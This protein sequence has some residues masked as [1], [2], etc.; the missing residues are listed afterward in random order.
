MNNKA[1][2]VAIAINVKLTANKLALN[3]LKRHNALL[4]LKVAVRIN[5][6]STATAHCISSRYSRFF[7]R[8]PAVSMRLSGASVRFSFACGE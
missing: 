7:L 2:A 3:T 6:I 8:L 4:A 5:P 1:D